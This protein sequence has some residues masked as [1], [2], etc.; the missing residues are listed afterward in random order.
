MTPRAAAPR[1]PR[2]RLGEHGGDGDGPPLGGDFPEIVCLD[3]EATGL[4]SSV[5]HVI[6]I[7]AV[8]FRGAEVIG[9]YHTLVNP[10]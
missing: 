4:S 5:E 1:R 9:R 6:E 3:L 7:G 8:R 10:G 2:G